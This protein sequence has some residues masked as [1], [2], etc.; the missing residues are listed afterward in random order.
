M[1]WKANMHKFALGITNNNPFYEPAR[2]LW[3]QELISGNSSGGSA[4]SVIANTAS[5]GADTGD[6]F[7]MIMCFRFQ[8]T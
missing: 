8:K 7:V 4:V 5:I 6:Q 3:N 2:N 1:F